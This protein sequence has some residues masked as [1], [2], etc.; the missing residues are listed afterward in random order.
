MVSVSMLYSVY[1]FKLWRKGLES[2][3]QR[4]LEKS[5]NGILIALLPTITMKLGMSLRLR[6]AKFLSSSDPLSSEGGCSIVSLDLSC[7]SIIADRSS[8]KTIEISTSLFFFDP[9][10]FLLAAWGL[11]SI[12]GA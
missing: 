2:K 4:T 3:G 10:S 6:S 1:A 8:G 9:S 5:R 11:K 12:I 7:L